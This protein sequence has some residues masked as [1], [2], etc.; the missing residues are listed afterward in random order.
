[1]VVSMKSY[2]DQIDM[3]ALLGKI[4]PLARTLANADTDKALEIVRAALPGGVI[5]GTSTGA[6]AWSW[7]IPPRWELVR[8]TVK[9][10]GETLVD[11]AWSVL[12]VINYSQ[13]FKG[14]VSREEL[15]KHVKTYPDRPNAIPFSFNF[16][17]PVWGFSIPHAWL[18]RFTSDVYEVEIDTRFEAGDLNTLSLFIP[19]QYKE[20]FI[21]C[22]DICHPLQVNDSLTGVATAVDI[23]N[24]LLSRPNRK[25]SYLVMVVPETIGSIAF[26]ANHPEVIESSIG[27]FFSEMLGTQGS[28]VGQRTRRGNGYWDKLLED[29]LANSGLP[30]KT[31]AFLK[32]ASND[33]KVLDSP[34]VDIPTF[35]ITRAPYPEY[36]TSDDNINLIDVERLREARNVLQQIVDYAEMDYIPVLNQPG[37]IFLS[38]HGLYP[39][40]R[41]DPSLLPIWNSF[42]DVMYCIDG[43]RS[44]VQLAAVH[45][46]PLAHFFYWT[47][48]FADKG[49]LTKRP[50]VL[51]RDVS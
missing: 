21:M 6:K 7:V 5:E 22:S 43:V 31:V 15:L 30:H 34:G 19:G 33:E 13:P 51:S 18:D 40:W 16:Y 35:S 4:A 50:F 28:M 38:G 10:N 26:L 29:V 8:A 32:S 27:G 25:Y 49:L 46:I 39:D 42:I 41:E 36:H 2:E 44:V 48:A 9:A 11:S 45:D 24:R 20:T 37:P 23:A 47:D 12:H 3:M 17:Q 14:T 1:M